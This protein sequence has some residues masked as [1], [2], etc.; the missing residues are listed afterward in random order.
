MNDMALRRRMLEQANLLAKVNGGDRA[1]LAFGAL[2]ST[3]GELLSAWTGEPVRV[4]VTAAGQAEKVDMVRGPSLDPTAD[5]MRDVAD[6][7][8]HRMAMDLECILS[9]DYAGNWY[10]S[11]MKTLGEYR[12]AM[13]AIH[14]RESPTHMGEPVLAPNAGHVAAG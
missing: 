9:S 2:L 5:A 8:A 12:A 1:L 4:Q 13:N 3:L 7:F 6:R 11:A 10:D 14:E